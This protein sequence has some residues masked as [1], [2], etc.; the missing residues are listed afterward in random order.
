[1]RCSCPPGSPIGLFIRFGTRVVTRVKYQFVGGTRQSLISADQNPILGCHVTRCREVQ[2]FL[3][4]FVFP[5]E[6]KQE[7]T[8]ASFEKRGVST[9]A[10]F[11]SILSRSERRVFH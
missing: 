6:E 10:V 2:G 4:S 8:T 1:M 11:G 3:F 9:Q 7:K 5:G